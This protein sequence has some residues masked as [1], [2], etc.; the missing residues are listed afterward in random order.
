MNAIIQGLDLV[1]TLLRPAFFVAAA[2]LTVVAAGD[3]AVRTRRINPFSAL[4]RFFRASVDPLIAPVER[5]IVRAGGLPSNAPWYALAAVVIGGI[6]IITILGFIQGQL[7]R[8]AFAAGMGTSGVLRL[9]VGWVF[10]FLQIALL[11]YVISGWVRVSPYSVWVRWAYVVSEP[12]LRPL[13]KI[14]PPIGGAIDITPLI[15]YFILWLI[16]GFVM[17]AL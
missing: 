14:V 6:I 15:A 17:R 1:I 2:V 3:W 9:L 11:V 16:E 4:A 5:R 7:S 12:L 10:G 8:A 13:R